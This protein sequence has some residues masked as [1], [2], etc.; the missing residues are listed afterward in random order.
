MGLVPRSL[1]GIPLTDY[2]FGGGTGAANSAPLC[3]TADRKLHQRRFE[4]HREVFAI[5]LDRRERS[6]RAHGRLLGRQPAQH[7][8]RGECV[9]V[10]RELSGDAA[11]QRRP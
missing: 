8:V 5:H 2:A 4:A 9:G 6:N 1:L 10:D 3:R 7:P 11:Q